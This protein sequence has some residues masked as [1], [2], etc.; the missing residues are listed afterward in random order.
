M[1]SLNLL[2]IDFTPMNLTL[3]PLWIGCSPRHSPY[4]TQDRQIMQI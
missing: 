3:R 4:T 1:G 2:S